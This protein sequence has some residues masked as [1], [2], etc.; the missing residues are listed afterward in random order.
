MQGDGNEHSKKEAGVRHKELLDVAAQPTLQYILKVSK[1]IL[2]IFF[3]NFADFL[4]I[5]IMHIFSDLT[6]LVI[7]FQISPVYNSQLNDGFKEGELL[8][9]MYNQPMP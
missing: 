9:V 8:A 3:K 5:K 4:Y 2:Q 7:L 6:H 1:D